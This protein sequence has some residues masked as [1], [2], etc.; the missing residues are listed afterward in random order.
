MN[1]PGCWSFGCRLMSGIKELLV[2]GGSKALIWLQGAL[3]GEGACF[4]EVLS[5]LPQIVAIPAA[6]WLRD[7]PALALSGQS[8]RPYVAGWK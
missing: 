7:S 6:N 3:S 8:H 1:C 5:S 4:T 2:L